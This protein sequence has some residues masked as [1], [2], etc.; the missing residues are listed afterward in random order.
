MGVVTLER[1]YPLCLGSNIGTTSTAILAALASD[2][3]T[4]SLS[5]QVALVHLFYNL[6]GTLFFYVVPAFRLPVVLARKMGNTTAKYRWFALVYLIGAF[7]VLP[8]IVFALSEISNA[9]VLAVIIPT[10]VLVIIV[11]IINAIKGR[12]PGLLPHFLRS[13]RWL[14]RPLRSLEPYDR[15]FSKIPFCNGTAEGDNE[16]LVSVSH[17]NS[18]EK[19]T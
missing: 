6:F 18:L 7:I 13:W 4:I 14:P 1:V 15:I 10:I 3:E 11:S 5:L 12:R 16:E 9:A 8:I 17:G 2:P 19:S